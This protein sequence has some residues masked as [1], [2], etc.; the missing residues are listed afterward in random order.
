[1]I[2]NNREI[3]IK[4]W[5]MEKLSGVI[6]IDTETD[7]RPFFQTPDLCLFQAYSIGDKNAY[8][9]PLNKVRLF[10]GKHSS[11]IL[12]FHNAKFDLDVISKFLESRAFSYDLLDEER[13]HDTS[14]LY[15]LWHLAV[16]GITPKKYSLAASCKHLLNME[17]DKDEAV[18]CTFDQYKGQVVGEIPMEHLEY[19]IKDVLATADLY[20]FLMPRIK[21]LDKKD[22]LLSHS[23]QIKGDLALG[24]I[25]KNGI[26]FNL[27]D[28]DTWLSKT[29][30]QMS[31]YENIMAT[32]GWV[33][34]YKGNQDRFELILKRLGV[35][36]KLPVT[37]SGK[38]ST[39]SADLEPFKNIGFIDAYLSYMELEKATTFV[40]DLE[41]EIVRPRYNL[42]VNTGRTSCS[43]PN[44]QQLPKLGG[45]RE[46]F[47]AREGHT[48]GIVDYS[49]IELSTLA[50]ELLDRFDDSMMAEQINM[51]N[52]LHKYYASV[53][54]GCSI[55]EVTK[56][57]RQEAKAA[58]FGF[59]GG[60]GIDTFIEFSRG[61]G[62][63]LSREQ[64]QEMKDAWFEAFPEIRYYMQDEKGSVY[65]R[66]GRLRNNTTYCAEKNTP[67]QGLAAD[68]AKLALYELDKKGFTIVGFVH[69]EIICEL[70]IDNA[71]KLLKEQE[72]IMVKAMREVVPDVK[73]GVEGSLSTF[74]TK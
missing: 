26:R 44:F 16:V 64:A 10:L 12:V 69:D 52:D 54:H 41:N 61:Y 15:R 48:F 46:M 56:Q 73:V 59:P 18:R 31:V 42:I 29:L 68:G 66:T 1:M 8:I 30:Q 27:K 2:Y 20:S 63:E 55:E 45:I 49:A 58:N 5:N 47:I 37:E 34:G 62:L 72:G 24:H 11:N 13:V 39:K 25:Y 33:R 40:R 7:V 36:D 60:L 50:Q 70:P 38:I 14:I 71:E 51:G 9:V 6:V 35:A 74:Y 19:A 57:W 32:W 3:T 21:M 17:L 22:T 43:S 28:R 67:F 23:I 4:N 53:M 65:T